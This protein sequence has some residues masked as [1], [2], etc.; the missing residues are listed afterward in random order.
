MARESDEQG[1]S[2][3]GAVG[4]RYRHVGKATPRKDARDIV[5]GGAVYLGDRKIPGALWGRVL[6]SPHPHALVR[7]VDK[8]RAEALP[9]VRAVLSHEDLPDWRLGTPRYTRPLDGKVRYVGDGVAL[10]AA[11]T[12][13]IAGEAVGLIHVEYEEL[14]AVYGLEEAL[15]P[16]APQLYDEAP[17]NVVQAGTSFFGPKCLTGLRTGDVEEGFRRADVV[18]EGTCGFQNIP[19]PLPAEAAGVVALWEEPDRVTFW[20]STQGPGQDR[21]ILYYAFG[22]KVDVRVI[23]SACGGSFGSKFMSIQLALQAAALSRATRRPVRLHMTREEQLAAFV[24]RVESKLRAK[25][26]MRRDGEVTAIS[27]DWLVGT[28]VYSMTTQAQVAVGCGEVQIAVRCANWDLR[29]RIVCTNRSA[30]GIIRGFGGQELKSALLPILYSAMEKLDVDPVDFFRKNYRKPGDEY[31]WRNGEKYVYRGI[32]FSEMM[33]AGARAF[34]WK[35]K[36]KGWL[37]PTAVNGTRRVGVG[38]GIHGCAD[39]GESVTEAYVR[40]DPQGRAVLYSPAT[41]HGT[42]QPTNLCK[43]V[44]EVLQLPLEGVSLTPPDTAVT[45]YD[46]GPVGSRGTWGMAS[47]AIEA[48]EDARRK[49]FELAAPLLG[50]GPEELETEDGQIF[51]RTAPERRIPWSKALTFDRTVLGQGRFDPD[52]TLTNCL[53]T[54]VEVE[55]DTETGKV[56]LRRVVNATDAGLVIDPPG[57]TNQLNG[58]LGSAGIDS[59]LF[60]E[61]ILDRRSGRVLTANMIDYKWRTFSELPEIRNVVLETP[62]PSHRFHAVGV[63]EIATAPG[64]AAVLLA[65]SN[66]IGARLSEYPLTPDRV[67]SALAR[68]SGAAAAVGPEARAEAAV[69]DVR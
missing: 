33:E 22:R 48:A 63:G 16:G 68:V 60:E 40:L 3:A 55:V 12:E 32:D 29:S 20:L 26:G 41:E 35:S 28:G 52:W 58:C 54:F 53:L 7:R 25:V 39:I 50:A 6:R 30:S 24:L 45:P 21:V 18:V 59:A 8:T 56:D 51:S 34:G 5:T 38:V 27:G 9:G 2:P 67:L 23:G 36:W 17:G 62:M 64:P 31:L 11:D 19:N 14:P 4:R 43:V 65:V 15:E 66:A 69:G 13:A 49:L 57:L 61:T 42:G 37:K 46:F 47:A 44:A 10:V 1:V